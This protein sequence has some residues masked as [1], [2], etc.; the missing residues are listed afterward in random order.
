MQIRQRKKR[1][2]DENL[3]VTLF[4]LCN[5]HTYSQTQYSEYKRARIKKVGTRIRDQYAFYVYYF[6][7]KYPSTVSM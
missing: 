6:Y 2:N 7:A 3:L 4:I 1:V 5:S